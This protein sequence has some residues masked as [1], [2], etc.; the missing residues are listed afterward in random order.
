MKFKAFEHF[1][2]NNYYSKYKIQLYKNLFSLIKKSEKKK[3]YEVKYYHT[4]SVEYL[5]T[6]III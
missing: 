1:K 2:L 5:M 4:K 3:K 6:V